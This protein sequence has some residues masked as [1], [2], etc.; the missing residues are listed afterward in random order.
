MP[1]DNNPMDFWGGTDDTVTIPSAPQ[2]A[3]NAIPISIGGFADVLN[4]VSNSVTNVAKSIA[5]LQILR[6]NIQTNGQQQSLK[7]YSTAAQIQMERDRIAGTL[8]LNK[9]ALQAQ[10][11]G[12]QAP[13][14]GQGNNL[15]MILTVI[16]IGVAIFALVKK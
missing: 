4:T 12:A 8:A 13:A 11:S 5:D 16:G 9:L 3:S 1:L 10:I 7:Q 2:T 6:D 15:M 14:G